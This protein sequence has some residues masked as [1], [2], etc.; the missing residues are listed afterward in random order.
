MNLWLASSPLAILL[1][2][3]VR[4]VAADPPSF[5]EV[6]PGRSETDSYL[7][8]RRERHESSGVT[9]D[10]RAS[11]L[12]PEGDYVTGASMSSFGPG[13]AFAL[14]MGLHPTRNFGVVFG[15]R[16]SYGH[17]GFSGC[18]PSST[19][20]GCGGYSLQVPVLLEYDA[21]NR[22]RGFFLQGGVG[23]FT[24]Y[25]AYG[26]ATTLTVKDTLEYK[27][28]IGW[29]I[30]FDRGEARASTF[31]ME[32]FAGVDFG[33]FSNAEVNDVDGDIAGSITAPAWHYA[34]ELGVGAHFTP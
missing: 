33:Q 29:R 5:A 4:A 25:H 7:E 11:L 13:S 12:V 23:L 1:F 28:Q 6:G 3:T 27:A 18:D 16:A 9:F 30:P 31:G 14:L 21:T 20:A 15:V 10:V 26:D 34:F 24:S 8:R 22:M 17:A 2:V 32:I 19:G